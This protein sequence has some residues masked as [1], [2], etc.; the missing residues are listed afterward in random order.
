[1]SNHLIKT[2]DLAGTETTT[3]LASST[4]EHKILQVCVKYE[5]NKGIL[6]SR[7]YY[8]L[9]HRGNIVWIGDY[10]HMAI[11]KYNEIHSSYKPQPILP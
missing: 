2:L 7:T 10:V 4:Q 11:N 3:V 8:T 5:I 1:M 6:F 9:K